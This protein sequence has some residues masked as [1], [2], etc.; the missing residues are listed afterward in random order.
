M[1]K[2]RQKKIPYRAQIELM[3][4]KLALAGDVSLVTSDG[5]L[6][7]LGDSGAN[8]ISIQQVAI[9]KFTISGNDGERIRY[10]GRFSTGP[11][12]V[13]T[14]TGGVLVSLGT[15]DDSVNVEG[16]S[17]SV[18]FA[19]F[20][21][22]L[23]GAGMD[24][25][26]VSA[27]RIGGSEYPTRIVVPSELNRQSGLIGR[28]ATLNAKSAGSLTI[29][30]AVGDRPMDGDQITIDQLTVNGP[31]YIQTGLGND[32][33]WMDS[34]VGRQTVVNTDAGTDRVDIA[35]AG[36]V[37]VS[38]LNMRLGSENDTVNIGTSTLEFTAAGTNVF[39]AGSGQN[40][41]AYLS[42]IS[43]T[44]VGTLKNPLQTGFQK[45]WLKPGDVQPFSNTSLR[46][47]SP[48]RFTPLPV[49]RRTLSQRSVTRSRSSTQG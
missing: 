2:M 23:T 33:I 7:I 46:P 12:S 16:L 1:H 14:V 34:I 38:S 36:P 25:V 15:G 18:P 22:I 31:S 21:T 35:V 26:T 44:S 3:E 42:N 19:H 27:L 5:N 8:Q 30:T 39:D 10:N 45:V 47:T 6:Q 43:I 40:S 9:G 24:K 11:V 32:S 20:L 48:T 29:D 49:I 4:Q 37:K 41:F 28:E 17:A 13:N